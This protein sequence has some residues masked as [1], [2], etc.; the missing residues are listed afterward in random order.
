MQKKAHRHLVYTI[1][2]LT[3]LDSPYLDTADTGRD[4]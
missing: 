4:K 1:M 3:D 2:Y